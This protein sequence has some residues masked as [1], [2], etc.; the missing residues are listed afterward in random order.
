MDRAS[1]ARPGRHKAFNSV[2]S[3]YFLN[4]PHTVV[5][6]RL[7]PSFDAVPASSLEE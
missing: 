2:G 3:Y 4:V 1:G 6:L 5:D 7:A